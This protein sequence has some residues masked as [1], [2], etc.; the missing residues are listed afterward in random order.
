MKTSARKVVVRYRKD[1]EMWQV[2]YRDF[3]GR[4]CRPLFKTEGDALDEA[5][6]V[7]RQ[8]G[9]VQ[10]TANPDVTLSEYA[11]KV[12]DTGL[13]EIDPRTRSDYARMFRQ[14]VEPMLGRLKVREIALPHV[15]G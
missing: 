5:A 2:D 4:R 8:M 3:S 15:K 11:A 13:G 7:R 14:H 10:L 12:L 6:R 1:R 9:I